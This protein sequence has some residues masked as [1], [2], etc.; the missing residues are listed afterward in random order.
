MECAIARI[1]N[2]KSGIK[3]RK[4]SFLNECASKSLLVIE[5]QM[6]PEKEDLSA[7]SSKSKINAVNYSKIRIPVKVIASLEPY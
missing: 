7:M 1:V 6:L 5:P 3:S 2:D 4:L